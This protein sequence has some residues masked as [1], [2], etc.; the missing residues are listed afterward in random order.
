MVW[1][2]TFGPSLSPGDAKVRIAVIYL[3]F[4]VWNPGYLRILRLYRGEQQHPELWQHSRCSR[5]CS[6]PLLIHPS[7]GANQGFRTLKWQVVVRFS[8]SLKTNE[9]LSSGDWRGRS[10]EGSR[11]RTVCEM[12]GTPISSKLPRKTLVLIKVGEPGEF[13]G[14][15]QQHHPVREFTGYSDR[16]VRKKQNVLLFIFGS[17]WLIDYWKSP[18]N[19]FFK[20]MPQKRRYWGMCGAREISVLGAGTYW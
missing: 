9:I 10:C 19:V 14:I 13:V 16:S 2:L 4:Q 8:S 6:R 7:F 15:I 3:P 1:G 20:G 12:Q 18:M 11:H 5:L 17:F